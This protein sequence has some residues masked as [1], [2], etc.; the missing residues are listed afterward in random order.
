VAIALKVDHG[1]K[2]VK[3]NIAAAEQLAAAKSARLPNL[4]V[5]LATLPWK[6]TLP[7]MPRHIGAFENP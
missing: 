4:S 7:Q 1:L 3:D 6:I 2:A 5:G